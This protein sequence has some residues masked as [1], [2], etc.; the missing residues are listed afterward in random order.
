MNGLRQRR[1]REQSIGCAAFEVAVYEAV[2]VPALLVMTVVEVV[3]ALAHMQ[4]VE[5]ELV[6]AAGAAE[7]GPTAIEA[8]HVTL[9]GVEKV[10]AEGR[11]IT[12]GP[13][14]M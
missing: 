9:V 7:V 11:G 8:A 14:G 10:P 3:W 1:C 13:G 2:T 5:A 6:A 12:R 4:A